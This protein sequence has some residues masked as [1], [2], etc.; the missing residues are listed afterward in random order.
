MAGTQGRQL[1]GTPRV[2]KSRLLGCYQ[3]LFWFTPEAMVS[4]H[5]ALLAFVL[6]H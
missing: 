4:S 2:C 1:V 6:L 3:Q 5:L